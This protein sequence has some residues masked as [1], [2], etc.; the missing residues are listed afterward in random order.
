MDRMFKLICKMI[1][2]HAKITGISETE[3]LE[4]LM[5]DTLAILEEYIHKEFSK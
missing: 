4:Q 3:A 5:P 1:R 2:I